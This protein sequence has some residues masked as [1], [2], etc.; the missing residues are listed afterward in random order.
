[1][2]LALAFV[3]DSSPTAEAASNL[4]TGRPS[5]RLTFRLPLL[6]P[7]GPYVPP[8]LERY[9]KY[10]QPEPF[11]SL[12]VI[13]AVHELEAGAGRLSPPGRGNRPEDGDDEGLPV[14]LQSFL[15]IT[16]AFLL[17]EVLQGYVNLGPRSRVTLRG[18]EL[19]RALFSAACRNTFPGYRTLLTHHDWTDLLTA[20]RKAVRT[21]STTDRRRRGEEAVE[22]PKA[23]LLRTLFG[24]KSAAA[25]DSF[26]RLLG[27][28]VETAGSASAFSLRF[29]L[30][31]GKPWPWTTSGGPAARELCRSA[32]SWRH[33]DMPG[34][35]RPRPTRSS[36]S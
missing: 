21:E 30:H 33:C 11:R 16:V 35:S 32:R 5:P 14:E 34:T 29:T 10:L 23:D 19:V 31:P 27:P 17:G 4:E 22:G 20:Y 25:G 18:L 8:E 15:G 6:R 1:V 2:D 7:L 12:T 26:L 28:L 9:H 3:C 24:Q 13:A 36:E